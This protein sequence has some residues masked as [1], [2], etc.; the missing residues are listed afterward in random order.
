MLEEFLSSSMVGAADGGGSR[1]RN[2]DLII[3]R[4]RVVELRN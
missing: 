1:V 3:S 2:T 4:V